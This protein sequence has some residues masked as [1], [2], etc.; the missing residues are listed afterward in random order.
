M[1]ATASRTPVRLL[2]TRLMAI[3]I[4]AGLLALQLLLNASAGPLAVASGR[5]P[6]AMLLAALLAPVGKLLAL[7]AIAA[8]AWTAGRSALAVRLWL[9]GLV[10]EIVA[11]LAVGQPAGALAVSLQLVLFGGLLVL[12]LPDRRR[13]LPGTPTVQIRFVPAAML[14]GAGALWIAAIAGTSPVTMPGVTADEVAEL[15]FDTALLGIALLAWFLTSVLARGR[16]WGVPAAAAL[17]TACL[18]LALMHRWA[19]PG[20]VVAGSLLAGASLAVLAGARNPTRAAGAGMTS[21]TE[22][23]T[24]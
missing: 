7:G 24:A 5:V 14:G 3:R 6:R 2:R 22:E 23:G 19:D 15:R 8:V 11:F 13:L 18:C 10:L 16:L 12:L 1:L 20:P 4:A 17:V 9:A 21:S